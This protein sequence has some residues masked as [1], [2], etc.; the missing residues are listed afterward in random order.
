LP[1]ISPTG[2]PSPE[3]RDV[4][5]RLVPEGAGWAAE[6]LL[7]GRAYPLLGGRRAAQDVEGAAYRGIS[8]LTSTFRDPALMQGEGRRLEHRIDSLA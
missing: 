1:A 3:D 8:L 4:A 5:G 2:Y 7:D 6:D